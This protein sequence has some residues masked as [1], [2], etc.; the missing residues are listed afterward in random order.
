MEG[1]GDKTWAHAMSDMLYGPSVN[2]FF[3]NSF[4]P[5]AL[6]L[7]VCSS[8]LLNLFYKFECNLYSSIINFIFALVEGTVTWSPGWNLSKYL[9]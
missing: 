4:F 7:H 3:S 8:I 6:H 9:V 5:L 1:G 2:L